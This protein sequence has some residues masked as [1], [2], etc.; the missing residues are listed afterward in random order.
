MSFPITSAWKRATAARRL[1][2]HQWPDARPARHKWNPLFQAFKE[3]GE[4]AG[5]GVTEDYNGERQEG[6]ADMEM[7]VHKGRRWSAANAYLKP[8]LNR[9][10]LRSDQGRAWSRIVIEETAARPAWSSRRGGEIREA[11]RPRE[12]VLAASA[13]NSPKLLMQSG[14][15]PAKHLPSLASMS[16]PTGPASAPTCRTTWNSTSSRPAPS[17]SRSTSTGTCFQGA[18]RRAMAVL[19]A[20]ASAPPTSSKL[21]LHPLAAGVEVSGHPV[22]FPALR[23]A[24]RRSRR[25]P[26]GH[27]FQAHVGPM[28]SKSRGR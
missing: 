8:A 21:R 13:I 2:R 20:R 12:V 15:G 26:K 23:R 17:R 16:S 24:L 7:T 25:R 4:Q 27:G 19:Q 5:Y 1:A 18:D 28:R 9:G 11:A 10:N 6:F 14:I 22:S 3:A